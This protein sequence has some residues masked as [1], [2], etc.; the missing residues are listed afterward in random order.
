M[1]I[2]VKFYDLHSSLFWFSVMIL[3]YTLILQLQMQ[4]LMTLQIRSHIEYLI[5]SQHSCAHFILKI[6]ENSSLT[7]SF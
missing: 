3:S 6:D 1:K 7:D 5:H 2:Y 4:Q